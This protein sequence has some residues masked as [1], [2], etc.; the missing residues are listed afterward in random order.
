MLATV[1]NTYTWLALGIMIF[2]G[3]LGGAINYF[4]LDESET[5][6]SKFSLLRG[7]LIGFGAALM[8]P[9]F[10]NMISSN[11]LDEVVGGRDRPGNFGKALVFL[12]FC[13]VAAVSS[14]AFIKTISDRILNEVKKTADEAK[15]EAEAAQ[16]KAEA[17]EQIV[18]EPEDEA[19]LAASENLQITLEPEERRILEALNSPRWSLRS[20]TGIMSDARFTPEQID[21]LLE[22]LE[23]RG[24]VGQTKSR[25]GQRWYLTQNGSGAIARGTPT[26]V[27]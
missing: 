3:T 17:V 27:D 14:R 5:S 21:P 12:G 23:H 25:G 19:P 2:A 4:L 20:K 6:T 9:L 15:K 16:S 7:M 22:R 1:E 13:L 24:L 10:L 26:K 11:L 8:V 18:T